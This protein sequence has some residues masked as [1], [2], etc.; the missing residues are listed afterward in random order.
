MERKNIYLSCHKMQFLWEIG[1]EWPSGDFDDK[2]GVALKVEL[3]LKVDHRVQGLA[4]GGDVLL[5]LLQQRRLLVRPKGLW[6]GQHGVGAHL[7]PPVNQ[8]NIFKLGGS[9]GQF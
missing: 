4:V 6:Q 1:L 2:G 7:T 3:A 9:M 8:T 5:K